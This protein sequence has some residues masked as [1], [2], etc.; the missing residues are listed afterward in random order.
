MMLNAHSSRPRAK[1]LAV[2]SD[3]GTCLAL[4]STG[5]QMF[6]ELS[7]E[8]NCQYA[9]N[10]LSCEREGDGFYIGNPAVISGGQRIG[11]AI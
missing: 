6:T 11:T 3:Q 5:G 4:G 2:G 9:P 7:N 10:G 8:G 1:F